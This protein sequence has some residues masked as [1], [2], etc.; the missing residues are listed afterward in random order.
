MGTGNM[1][2]TREFLQGIS[3]VDFA[4]ASNPWLGHVAF[5]HLWFWRGRSH[6]L[7]HSESRYFRKS[8]I[9]PEI[10][11][12]GDHVIKLREAETRGVHSE[13]GSVV[14]DLRAETQTQREREDRWMARS[15]QR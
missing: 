13:A 12:G 3:V 4:L 2:F 11:L 6:D 10:L 1:G 8:E 5:C 9:P 14:K 15:I 7:E